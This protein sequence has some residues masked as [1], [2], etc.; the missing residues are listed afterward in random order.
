[1]LGTFVIF[2][3][4]LEQ[5]KGFETDSNNIFKKNLTLRFLVKKWL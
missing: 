5:Y 2:G 3:M 4:K 1:M